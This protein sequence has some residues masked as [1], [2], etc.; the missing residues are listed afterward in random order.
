MSGELT[1]LFLLLRRLV[2]ARCMG[3]SMD[4]VGFLLGGLN[5]MNARIFNS[6]LVSEPRL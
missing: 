3:V 5:K 4:L 6:N 2:E 1:A